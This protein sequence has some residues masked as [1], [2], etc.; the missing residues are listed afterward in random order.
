MQ[1]AQ[2]VDRLADGYR[3]QG[4][5]VTVRPVAG[6]LPEFAHD[7]RIEIVGR[8]GTG[9]VLVAA[10]KNL[11]TLAADSE[12]PRYAEVTGNQPGWRFDLAVLEAENVNARELSG[13]REFSASDI[14][15]SLEQAQELDRLGYSQAAV[16]AAW[17]G[18]EAAMRVRLRAAGEAANWESSPR[19]TVR[20][21]Y[22][23]G[24][25]TPDEF[26]SIESAR[27]FRSRI[28]HGFT[29]SEPDEA[30]VV[31][32]LIEVARRLV[33]ESQVADLPA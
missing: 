32:L 25:L 16:V 7:F 19:Q 23:A 17:A 10:R 21:L 4:Y 2:D 22:S 31:Q 27:Q 33:E 6:Q 15:R 3:G 9:G 18:L 1:L 5:D 24:L 26:R 28:V 13:A 29:T 30:A 20:E 11:S 12:L 14:D 8:R